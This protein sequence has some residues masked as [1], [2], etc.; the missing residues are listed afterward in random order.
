VKEKDHSRNRLEMLK[1]LTHIAAMCQR[2]AEDMGLLS[3]TTGG[4]DESAD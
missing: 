4:H 1:E 2:A 3:E